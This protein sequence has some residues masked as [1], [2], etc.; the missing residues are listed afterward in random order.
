MAFDIEY[1]TLRHDYREGVR[2]ALNN[3]REGSIQEE[4]LDR[5][6]NFCMV[7]LM[8]MTKVN[9][10]TWRNAEK[11][12]E[13]ADLLQED[14]NVKAEN[15]DEHED[16]YTNAAIRRSPQ[17]DDIGRS[18]WCFMGYPKPMEQI[19]ESTGDDDSRAST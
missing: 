16:K 14:Q 9:K 15:R 6:H 10:A 18:N 4:D 13:L 17:K 1:A 2:N 12:A 7:A 3:I 8:L 11:M 19:A 5:L